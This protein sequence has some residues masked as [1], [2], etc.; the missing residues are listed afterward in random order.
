MSPASSTT[1]SPGTTSRASITLS[2]PL[3]RTRVRT[4]AIFI[5]ASIDRAARSSV[6]KPIAALMKRSATMAMPSASSPKAKDR[7][8]AKARSQTI[9]LW[10]WLPRMDRRLRRF[11]RRSVLGPCDWRR[12]RAFL[13]ER[14][15]SISASSRAATSSKDSAKG[16]WTSCFATRAY[17]FAVCS[18]T[19][20]P[21]PGTA[22][23]R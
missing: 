18:L 9:T 13:A 20:R 11:C 14:P 15:F 3:R 19:G 23:A 5:S 12:E 8:A 17:L 21:R 22:R 10:N 7:P 2:S 16:C 4:S 6:K 1:R